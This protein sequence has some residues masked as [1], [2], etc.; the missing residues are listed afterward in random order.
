MKLVILDVI[1]KVSKAGNPYTQ[2]AI[3]GTGKNG[4]F[5][6]VATVPDDTVVGEVLDRKVIFSNGG[7]FVLP[8]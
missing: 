5:L 1:S 2:A 8:Y 3:R 6:F 4:D 7:G